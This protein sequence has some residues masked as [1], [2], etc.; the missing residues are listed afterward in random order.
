MKSNQLYILSKKT[1]SRIDIM[2]SN[3]A[4]KIIINDFFVLS[5]YIDIPEGII[6]TI[7]KDDSNSFDI[8]KYYENF[9]INNDFDKY[10]EQFNYIYQN[11]YYLNYFTARIIRFD[12]DEKI[13]DS[14][15]YSNFK[16]YYLIFEKLRAF[17]NLSKSS[18]GEIYLTI[19]IDDYQK[20]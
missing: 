2:L 20:I 5:S 19:C 13:F 14:D 12:F 3:E 15:Q 8:S 7:E 10:N 11:P 4:K 6:I 1:K 18:L 9:D 17:N 16:N